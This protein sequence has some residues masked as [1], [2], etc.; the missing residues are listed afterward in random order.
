M[1]EEVVNGPEDKEAQAALTF[2]ENALDRMGLNV[3]VDARIEKKFL[4]IR[5]RGDDAAQLVVGRGSAAKSDVLDS[6]QLLAS[7]SIYPGEGG[8]TIVIDANDYRDARLDQLAPAADRLS[9]L[10]LETKQTVRVFGMNSFDRRAIH[11]RLADRSDVVTASEGDGVFRAI[12]ITSR[13]ALKPPQ[14]EDE[15]TSE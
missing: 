12:S 11:L 8:R 13:D 7:R 10:A 2:L 6:L 1:S 9:E 14:S 15:P 5:I 3:T 4:R